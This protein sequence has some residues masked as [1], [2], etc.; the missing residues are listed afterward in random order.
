MPGRR[1]DPERD[2]FSD[3]PHRIGGD[4]GARLVGRDSEGALYY[5]D[6]E[7]RVVVSGAPDEIPDPEWESGRRLSQEESLT[8]VIRE[9]EADTGWTALSG[10][11]KRVRGE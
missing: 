9:V 11:A 8:H 3:Y 1:T 10:Y 6:A 5:F 2:P 4:D 7:N